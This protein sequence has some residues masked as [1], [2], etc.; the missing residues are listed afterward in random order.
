MAT[1]DKS[2]KP[3]V[4]VGCNVQAA[5]CRPAQAASYAYSP[6]P[7]SGVVELTGDQAAKLGRIMQRAFA[8]GAVWTKK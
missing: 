2:G 8:S 5:P 3:P 7:N 1:M 4:L 6:P